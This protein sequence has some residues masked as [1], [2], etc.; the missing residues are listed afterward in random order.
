MAV[1]VDLEDARGIFIDGTEVEVD[2]I[3]ALQPQRD[4]RFRILPSLSPYTDIVFTSADSKFIVDEAQELLPRAKT[5]N[6]RR[7]LRR[8]GELAGRCSENQG[9][10]LRITGE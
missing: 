2:D 8:L 9:W 1:A 6:Q 4:A 7:Y 10:I 5:E 3:A